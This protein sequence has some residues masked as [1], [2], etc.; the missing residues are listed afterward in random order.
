V[1]RARGARAART[2]TRAAR[3]PPRARRA[4]PV[5]RCRTWCGHASRVRPHR[6][7]GAGSV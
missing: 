3:V 1:S 2:W 4:G 5:Q 6:A 7:P